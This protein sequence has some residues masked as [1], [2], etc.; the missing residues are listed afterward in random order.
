[1]SKALE[2][3]Q[4]IEEIGYYGQHDDYGQKGYDQDAAEYRAPFAD[5]QLPDKDGPLT[6]NRNNQVK[7]DKRKS[8]GEDGK[9]NTV[10]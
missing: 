6:G 2:L 10:Q 3:I 1:M 8:R 4:K 5:L 9:G 7:T